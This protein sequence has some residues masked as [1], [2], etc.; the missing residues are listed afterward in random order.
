MAFRR[1][2]PPEDRPGAFLL[3][4]PGPPGDSGGASTPAPDQDSPARTRII[5]K[6]AMEI[7]FLVPFAL[8]W[9]ILQEARH[10]A[11]IHFPDDDASPSTGHD[12]KD[13]SW[14]DQECGDIPPNALTAG[15]GET[16]SSEVAHRGWEDGTRRRDHTKPLPAITDPIRTLPGRCARLIRGGNNV[17]AIRAKPSRSPSG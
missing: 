6:D 8:I 1:P 2:P 17:G 10:L 12:R 11:L 3:H 5:P 15:K 4:W 16:G 13:D 7:L 9:G 14:L